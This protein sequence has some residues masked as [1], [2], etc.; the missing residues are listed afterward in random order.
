VVRA[1]R[2]ISGLCKLVSQ[3]TPAS[4]GAQTLA[5]LMARDGWKQHRQETHQYAKVFHVLFVPLDYRVTCQFNVAA[6]GV[7]PAAVGLQ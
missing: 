4:Y 1:C 6:G 5:V 3:E 2:A 7:T